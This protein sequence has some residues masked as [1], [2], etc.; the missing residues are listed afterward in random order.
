MLYISYVFVLGVDNAAYHS[1]TGYIGS[2]VFLYV[3]YFLIS[4]IDLF[5]SSDI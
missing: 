4:K 1:Y 2:C 3:V 5:A